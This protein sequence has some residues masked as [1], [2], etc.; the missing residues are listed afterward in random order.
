MRVF[1]LSFFIS[2]A[3]KSSLQLQLFSGRASQIFTSL[4][5]FAFSIHCGHS[6]LPPPP[7]AAQLTS[8]PV[9]NEVSQTIPHQTI[10]NIRLLLPLLPAD[11]TVR[12][13]KT[14]EAKEGVPQCN[15]NSSLNQGYNKP[16]FQH[17]MALKCHKKAPLKPR[18]YRMAVSMKE[19]WTQN[20]W[21]FS[22]VWPFD[23]KLLLCG[24]FTLLC[25]EV[26]WKQRIKILTSLSKF[27]YHNFQLLHVLTQF[28]HLLLNLHSCLL[29]WV[30]HMLLSVWA[31]SRQA[32][33]SCWPQREHSINNILVPA[34]WFGGK[35]LT[36]TYWGMEALG[37]FLSLC[38]NCRQHV[39]FR[40]KILKLC[41][42][43]VSI[44]PPGHLIPYQPALV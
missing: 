19:N 27:T 1:F 22:F 32:K 31:L 43:S 33:H 9:Q 29:V 11:S 16:F 17:F 13:T 5:C 12:S 24:V 26:L 4:H 37:I 8:S 36:V 38:P 40:N 7:H 3:A 6:A 20:F 2:T 15:S 30:H 42:L 39:G 14:S 28:H 21:I 18:P 44:C 10:A 41:S 25:T 35:A 34:S 23:V